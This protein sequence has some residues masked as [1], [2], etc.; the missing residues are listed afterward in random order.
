MRLYLAFTLCARTSWSAAKE[1]QAKIE[2]SVRSLVN[3]P[4][5]LL[6]LTVYLEAVIYQGV[7]NLTEALALYQSSILSLPAPAE[8]R[9][10][11]QLSLDISILSTLNTILII[12]APSHPQ[13]KI[14]HSLVSSVESLCLQNQNHQIC[15]AYHLVAAT[16]SSD[17]IVLT[18]QFLQSALQASKQTDNKHLMCMVLNFMSWKFFRG[19]VGEQAERS[20]RASQNL[21]QQCMN[22]LWMSVSAGLLSDTLEVAGRNE[23]AERARQSG[24]KTSSSLP[25]ALQ[26][27]MNGNLDGHDVPMAEDGEIY[28]AAMRVNG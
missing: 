1:Q 8:Q 23:E 22:G 15:S 26:E 20:A 11:S 7:G 12:R 19:V 10:R 4:E 16:T 28:E 27:A 3:T 9:V 17:T 14:V 21:A 2:A 13:N 5:P 6:L 24:V 18:K 25:Q